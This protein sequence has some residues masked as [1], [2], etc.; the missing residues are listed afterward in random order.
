[1]FLE[2]RSRARRIVISEL[3]TMVIVEIEFGQVAMRVLLPAMLVDALHGALEN[4]LNGFSPL[5]TRSHGAAPAPGPSV[6]HSQ[7]TKTAQPAT[8]KAVL[9]LLSR[10]TLPAILSRQ[11]TALVFRVT[12]PNGQS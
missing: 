1:M 5:R 9:F 4:L 7:T 6:S 10:A 12:W 11:K 8:S 3:D 2:Q